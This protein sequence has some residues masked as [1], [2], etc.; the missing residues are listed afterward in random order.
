MYPQRE[1]KAAL[2]DIF[3]LHWGQAIRDMVALGTLYCE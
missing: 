2:L 1:Q 3:R